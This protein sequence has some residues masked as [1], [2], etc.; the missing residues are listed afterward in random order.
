MKIS[1]KKANIS[2]MTVE[3]MMEKIPSMVQQLEKN[4]LTGDYRITFRKLTH[5]GYLRKDGGKLKF[6]H[7]CETNSKGQACT[8]LVLAAGIADNFGLKLDLFGFPAG[9]VAYEEI[10]KDLEDVSSL[11]GVVPPVIPS[12]PNPSVA[13]SAPQPGTTAATAAPVEKRDWKV[14]WNEIKEYLQDQSVS[15]RMILQIREKRE[16]ICENV[17]ITTMAIPPKKPKTPYIGEMLGRALRHILM[18]N[19]LLLQGDKGSGKDTLIATLS[20]ILSLPLYLQIGNADETKESVVGENS[21]VQGE[22][23]MEVVFKKSSFATSVEYGGISSY[24]ELNMLSGDVTSIFHSVLDENRILSTP[25]GSIQRHPHH[26]FIG[27]INVGDQYAGTK[28][29]N[30][31][32][33]DRLS[34]IKLPYVQDFRAMIISKSGLTDGHALDF[35]ESTKKAIDDLVIAEQQG[36]EAKTIRGYIKAARYL[37]S[38]GVTMETK[39]ECLEDFIIHSAT[40]F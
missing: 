9:P 21:I 4:P 26:L 12:T 2:A 37:A 29:I 15:A 24:P 5:Y 34:I 8:H 7:F 23:G 31:A 25:E 13:S 35:L 32:F 36:D 22:R 14:E 18:G 19:D 39:T 28:K 11:I 10:D 27:S 6:D 3:S 16:Q 20:W 30:G 40:R 38:Y 17:P 33:K 1:Y